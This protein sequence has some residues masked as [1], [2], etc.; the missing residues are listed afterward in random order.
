M[1]WQWSRETGTPFSSSGIENWGNQQN[2]GHIPFIPIISLL[3][4]HTTDL[5][6]HVQNDVCIK[7]FIAALFERAKRGH[8]LQMCK[9]KKNP[10]TFRL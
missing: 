3:G 7:I 5:F 4:I 10:S 6:P 9:K 8:N 1:C 2:I